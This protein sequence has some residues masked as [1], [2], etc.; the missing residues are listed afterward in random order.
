MNARLFIDPPAPGSW[1]MAVDE[2]LLLDAAENGTAS[3]RFYNWSEPTLSLGYFQRYSDR[4]QHAASRECALV[5]RQTGGGAILQAC[6]PND[7]LVLPESHSFAKRSQQ[8]YATVH[9]TIIETLGGLSP[10][11]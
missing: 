7:K 6:E 5:R 4:E 8:L 2:A 11:N 3:L 9:Q 10:S 1:N